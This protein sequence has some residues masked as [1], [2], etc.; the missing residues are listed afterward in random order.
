MNFGLGALLTVTPKGVLK[1]LPVY[2]FMNV[3]S[4]FTT[5]FF[6]TTRNSPNC[7]SFS[8]QEMYNGL[9]AHLFHI[10]KT[11]AIIKW[12]VYIYIFFSNVLES[13]F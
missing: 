13:L 4:T 12:Y 2:A 5:E 1:D 3:K 8:F 9:L 6:L 7:V 10:L 11:N